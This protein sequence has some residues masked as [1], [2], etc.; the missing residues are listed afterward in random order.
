[1]NFPESVSAPDHPLA[2]RG[3]E[4]GGILH[5]QLRQGGP[6]DDPPHFDRLTRLG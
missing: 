1:M 6:E 5:L 3:H 4:L 2:G